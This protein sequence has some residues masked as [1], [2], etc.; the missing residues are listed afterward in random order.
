MLKP[1]IGWVRGNP[2]HIF[3][4]PLGNRPVRIMVEGIHPHIPKALL[5]G[6]RVPAL[7]YGGRPI[8]D[9]IQPGRHLILQQQGISKLGQP[10]IRQYR[11][12]DIHT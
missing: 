10:H 2:G 1:G 3:V 8:L 9:R 7:P 4:H 11:S 12:D 6:I 5:R